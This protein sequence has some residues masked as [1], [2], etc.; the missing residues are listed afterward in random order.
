MCTCGKGR[1]TA[2][3]KLPKTIEVNRSR[4]RQEQSSVLKKA[5]HERVVVVSATTDDSEK[6]IVD[7]NYF[8]EVLEQWRAA[9]ETLE[10]AADTR[11]F[12]NLLRAA[13]TIDEDLRK[14]NLHTFE[15]AFK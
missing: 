8:E 14:G 6:Y 4:L 3:T 12:N 7:K 15:D 9:V 5:I 13:S 2:V 1:V 11:L 10:I